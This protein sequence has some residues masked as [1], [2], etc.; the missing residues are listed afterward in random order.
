MLRLPTFHDRFSDNLK[1]KAYTKAVLFYA[2]SLTVLVLTY[3]L[4][5]DLN[6]N[7]TQLLATAAAL[8]SAIFLAILIPIAEQWRQSVNPSKNY[9]SG[10]TTHMGHLLKTIYVGLF[11]ALLSFACLLVLSLD[12]NCSMPKAVR[13]AVTSAAFAS[14]L[15]FIQLVMQ[16]VSNTFKAYQETPSES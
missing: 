9:P 7:S 14:F 15:L 13:Q 16:S 5:I 4:K 10:Y 6:D 2:P 8:F 12:S 1:V 3:F 11:V